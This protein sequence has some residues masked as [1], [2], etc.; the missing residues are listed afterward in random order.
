MTAENLPAS[1][2]DSKS[3]STPARASAKY[4]FDY[5]VIGAGSGGVRSSR[6]AA[7]HGAKVGIAEG[8]FYG[9]TC[10]NVGCVPKKLLAYAADFRLDFETSAGYGWSAGTPSFNWKTL[11]ANKDK[12]IKRLN[13]IYESLLTNAGVK[14]FND[15]AAFVDPHTL[16]IGQDI[17]TAKHI[18]IAT[19][20]KPRALPV[21]GG[22]HA[23][24]SD[25]AFYLPDLPKSVVICGG[26]YIA[27][28]FAH[29]F[30]N[31]GSDVTLVYRG[32]LFLRGFDRDIAQSL[33]DTMAKKG[34][35][36]RFNTDIDSITKTAAGDYDV[37][38]TDGS[39]LNTALV[40]AAIGRDPAVDA[41]DLAKA[42][43]ATAPNGT[44]PVN[45]QYQTNVPHIHAVGD[46]IG[47]VALTPVALAEGHFLAD[48][49]F[50]GM[51]RK[52]LDY[53]TIPSAVFSDP[54]I[55]TIG[56]TE[57]QA[58]AKGHSID[59]YKSTFSPM[60]YSLAGG[61]DKTVMKIIVDHKTDKILGIHMIGLDVP[62]ILQG[63][64]VAVVAGATKADFD[65][66][67]GIHPT[68][69][70][71]LVTMRKPAYSKP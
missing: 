4:D 16:K 34:I 2:T 68:S 30:H 28:E 40:M 24:V 69:A 67:I 22:E 32:D 61:G 20:G 23:I 42:G 60:K 9:G 54:A 41:L 64:A 33:K 43:V 59:V 1:K 13:G 26:G 10:V 62:E 7:A 37:A 19:G 6:I 36:L 71:E 5:F 58:L 56:M 52:A 48:T 17:V 14:I 57:E 35:T 47:R 27:V 11:I 63:F 53:S 51:T 29:I 21:K 39:V 46:I 3:A 55:G 38:M 15:Y 65:R 44:I 49:L 18:L 31:L 25:D 8:R 66:T 50:G 45:G 70:E 12:E